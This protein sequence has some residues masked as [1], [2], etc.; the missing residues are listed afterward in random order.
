MTLMIFGTH[1]LFLKQTRKQMWNFQIS[2][3]MLQRV[4]MISQMSL[5]L[6]QLVFH[7]VM[8]ILL[9]MRKLKKS[10]HYLLKIMSRMT[11]ICLDS[12]IQYPFCNGHSSLLATKKIGYS[13]LEVERKINF[14]VL[15]LLF[16]SICQSMEKLWKWLRSTFCVYTNL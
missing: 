3:L 11:T 16:L 13:A 4:L 7:G 9:M 10:I 1:N 15:F 8:L 5:Y 6:Y 14:L 12:I 2:Q